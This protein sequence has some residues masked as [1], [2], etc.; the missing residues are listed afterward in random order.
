MLLPA[1]ILTFLEKKVEKDGIYF[2]GL[3]KE[4]GVNYLNMEDYEKALI[5]F[6]KAEQKVPSY[7][8]HSN[9]IELKGDALVGVG[10]YNLASKL[11][12]KSIRNYPKTEKNKFV[13]K[14][15]GKLVKTYCMQQKI[16]KVCGR[17]VKPSVPVHRDSMR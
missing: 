10:E 7:N 16:E 6:E 8:S 9:F 12:K 3:F 2:P 15:Y 14:I 4:I 5:Y 17:G 13:E 1:K 11:Y